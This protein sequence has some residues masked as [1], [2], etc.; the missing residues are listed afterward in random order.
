[1]HN[2]KGHVLHC[3]LDICINVSQPSLCP[4]IPQCELPALKIIL[5]LISQC[6][7]L[8]YGHDKKIVT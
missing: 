6:D 3:D 5:L 7:V 4:D 8:I 1:M 2:N